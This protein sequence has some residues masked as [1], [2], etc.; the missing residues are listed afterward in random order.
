MILIKN[1]LLFII[2]MSGGA[3]VA[4]AVFS[5][6]TMLM[7]VPRMAARTHTARYIKK[8]ENCIIIGGIIGNIIA[9]YSINVPIGII[10]LCAYGLFSG[11]FVGML[12]MALAEV[13]RVIPIFVMRM[14]LTQGLP[15]VILCIA[16]GKMVATFFQFFYK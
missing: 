12:A 9:I 7:I 13:L 6:I 1:I 11:I 16:I 2:G 15:I 14:K 3:I 4:S 8:Y 5:F 10:G